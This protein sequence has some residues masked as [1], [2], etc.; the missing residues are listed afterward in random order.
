M[1]IADLLGVQ[2]DM[3]LL[4]KLS[5]SVAAVLLISWAYK[6]YR[7]RGQRVHRN[8][9]DQSNGN[10]PQ[11]GPGEVT[12]G[13]CINCNSELRPRRKSRPG[14]AD[15]GTF[16]NKPDTGTKAC[17]ISL[18]KDPSVPADVHVVN[19]VCPVRQG[20]EAQSQM[21]AS[22][23]NSADAT[24]R[25]IS[26]SLLEPHEQTDSFVLSST[27]SPPAAKEL[28]RASPTGGRSPRLLRKLEPSGAGVGRELRQDLEHPG[29]YF[30]FQSKAEIKVEDGDLLL[31]RPG[32][33]P[34]E[35]RGKIYDYYV[36]SA[37][38]SISDDSAFQRRAGNS[39]G[40]R[41]IKSSPLTS[42]VITRDLV[43]TEDPEFHS[44]D[45][46]LSLMSL[47][48]EKHRHGLIRKE[49][50]SQIVENS[51]LQIPFLDPRASTPMHSRLSS[52]TASSEDL[53]PSPVSP[54]TDSVF[55][56]G[57][58]L[59]MVAGANFLQMPME[60]IDSSEL[61]SLK[62]KLDLGNCLQALSLARKH[63]IDDLQQAVLKI[64]SDNY[65]QVLR[66]PGLYGKL[67]ADDR[68]QIQKQRMKG[69]RYLVVADI[70]PQ[71]WTRPNANGAEAGQSRTSSR[72]Y[73]YDD[74][75]DIWHPLSSLPKE[76]ISKGCS[77]CTMDNYLFIAAGCQGSDLKP[78][79]S[80]FCYN[81]V[82]GIWKEICPLNEARPQCKLVALQG[83]VYAIGGECLY[84]VERYDPRADRWSFVAPL[85]ND[86][87][88]VAHRATACNGQLFVSGGTLKYTLLRYNPKTDS[89][90]VSLIV[91]S[92][93][94]TTE[95][96]AIRNFIYRFDVN[97]ALGIS[98]YRYHVIARLWYE[99]STKRLPYCAAFQ[100]ANIDN[101]I[102]CINR[103]FTVRFVADEVS[104]FFVA[105][106]LKVLTMAKGILFPLVLV[107]PEKET[108][109]TR[110]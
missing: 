74:Y 90:K 87:F 98:V 39:G 61:E 40:E 65:L 71:D 81:P 26:S 16:E 8:G 95:M 50:I 80:V 43:F 53:C 41:S 105:D 20:T 91:G 64:M 58:S 75:K 44:K 85:P 106:E 37:S 21:P 69:R 17:D 6:F 86:T 51:D 83:Y 96:V 38:Q 47:P 33:E 11:Q 2:V 15:K 19:G 89:W 76:V 110:V 42:P 63:G 78:S 56:T 18:A 94:R 104:P 102:Y 1:P 92:K 60:N 5:V 49:S 109:Q 10:V 48:S 79:R 57:T 77:M 35:V 84:T 34:L 30:S 93:E 101:L 32:A 24:Q 25:E 59:E 7:S 82:T 108:L 4:G 9:S 22:E 23:Q 107:L 70:D 88:A 99:C 54:L 13:S 28:G 12:A 100:C 3:Q 62:C 45:A 68:D 36:E 29:S 67:R 14:D 27:L 66:D 97:P 46:P 52:R 55:L 31:E 73:F 72:L 103:Q